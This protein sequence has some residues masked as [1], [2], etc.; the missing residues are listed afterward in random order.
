MEIQLLVPSLAAFLMTVCAAFGIAFLIDG[1]NN[2]RLRDRLQDVIVT[3]DSEEHVKSIILR[4]LDLSTIPF[5]NDLLKKVRWARKLET[6]LIQAD[7]RLRVGSFLI[8]AGL[9][10][11]LAAFFATSVLHQ[12][13]L[14][15]PA[16]LFGASLPY[17]YVRQKK[18]KRVRKFEQQFP[19]ALDMLTGA[20]RAGLAWTGAIQVVAD[21]S[22][23]PVAT[24]FRVLFEENRLGLDMRIA[25]KR[26]AERMD[27][28]ELRLFVTAVALQRE[29]GGNLAEVLEGTAVVIRDRFRILGD[30]R[31]LTAQARL[32]VLILIVMPIVMA[33]VIGVTSPHYLQRLVND[34][35][36]PFLIATAVVLQITGYVIMR[37]IINIKV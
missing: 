26:L 28:Q 12:A 31:S 36:G 5:I 2:K 22:P 37:R 6:L 16:V 4:D 7:V 13:W 27:S 33:G 32:S 21:E 20:L 9:S 10:G 8:L 17:F 34:P 35:F 19:D 11:S 23:D 30:V 29:T 18:Q 15:L 1:I 24:E 14:T 25:L 3:E